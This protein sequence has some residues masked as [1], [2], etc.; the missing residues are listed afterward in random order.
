VDSKGKVVGGNAKVNRRF[1]E[2]WTFIRTAGKAVAPRHDDNHCPNCGAPLDNVNAAG[3]CAYCDT[4]I[5][6]GDY[7]WVLSRIEQADVYAG[8]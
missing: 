7:D 4:K 8:S 6:T 1:S 5:V 2:Y 3:V